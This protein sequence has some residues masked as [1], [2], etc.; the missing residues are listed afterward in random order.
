[1]NCKTCGIVIAKPTDRARR[2]GYAFCSTK[3]RSPQPTPVHLILL[4]HATPEPNTGCFLWLGPIDAHGYGQINPKRRRS[5]PSH[6]HKAHRAAWRNRFGS[7]PNGLVVCHKCDERL[8]VNPDHLFLG[9]VAD[10]NRDAKMK[11]R[12]ARGHHHGKAKL[13]EQQVHDIRNST[14]PGTKLAIRYGVS[15]AAISNVRTG[16][17]WE[18]K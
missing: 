6:E 9:T 11:K 18:T 4:Q 16:A 12:N 5:D 2:R 1:M 7:I 13:T 8:C 14:D 17:R 3:C 10:N 15:Q